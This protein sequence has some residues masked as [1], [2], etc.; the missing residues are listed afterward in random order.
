MFHPKSYELI[1]FGDGIKVE[2][3]GDKLIARE[4]P[5]VDFFDL[6]ELI[7][8]YEVD[9]SFDSREDSPIWHGQITEDWNFQHGPLRMLLRQTP[10]GQV[11]VFPEQAHNWNWIERHADL[12][13][14]KKAIN[15][16]AYTGGTTLALAKSGVEVTHVDSAS[17]VVS[18]ARANAERSTL[19]DWPIRWI[20]EDAMRFMRREI[21]RGKRYDIFIADPPS[22]GR[23]V[24]KEV[25]KI[26]RD[27][28]ELMSL[29]AEL[30]P[31][32]TM[33]ILS[34]HTPTF[35]AADLDHLLRTRFRV[36][37]NLIEEFTLTLP[38]ID[39]RTLPAGECARFVAGT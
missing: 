16:F 30:C 27:L 11:G 20:V 9:A 13:D 4:S 1:D 33:A 22:F 14:G 7:D 39:G 34:C 36:D 25:W 24:K 29:A 37:A 23:G 10:S 2:R 3:F 21:K 32:P 12:L 28:G 19:H 38:S 15:L 18:W 6:R 26:E 31:E 17:S 8:T 35:D 5:S